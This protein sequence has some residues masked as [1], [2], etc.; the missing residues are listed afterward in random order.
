MLRHTLK[1]L[2]QLQQVH[3]PGCWSTIDG[4]STDAW[5]VYG[6]YAQSGTNSLWAKHYSQLTETMMTTSSSTDLA[7][8]GNEQLIYSY[9]LRS[10]SEP[11]DF[12][13]LLSTTG[14]AASDFT[15]TLVANDTF[16]NITYVT[17]TY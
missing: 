7:V 17:D 5:Q 1:T 13:V 11:N 2:N 4:G 16:S 15:T 9:R 14:T 8:T 6:G 3:Y 12:E 10:A